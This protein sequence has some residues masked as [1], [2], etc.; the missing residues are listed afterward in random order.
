MVVSEI[1]E[2]WSPITAP[3]HTA[4]TAAGSRELPA[5]TGTATGMRMPMVPQLVPVAKAS[6]PPTRNSTS[7][8]RAVKVSRPAN[9]PWTKAAASSRA[10]KDFSPQAKVSTS[11]AGVISLKPSRKPST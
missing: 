10:A 9:S 5:N 1:G 11:S 7:G 3:A 8:N 4:A 6:S 2:Q